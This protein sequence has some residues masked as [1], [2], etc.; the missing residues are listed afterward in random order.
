L[1]AR[2]QNLAG[3]LNGANYA[4]WDPEVDR[5]IPQK[6]SSN[7]L[8]FK[9]KNKQ[10]LLKRA[11]LNFEA[12]TPVIGMISRLESDKGFDLLEQAFDGLMAL[13]AQMIVLGVGEEKYHKM[14][15]RFAKKY[16][17]RLSV[18]LRFDNSLAHLIQ[19]GA[20]MLLMP[21]RCEPC[22][23]T[24]LHALRY[25]TIPIV[26]ATGG[27]ADTV[28][29]YEAKTEAGTGFVFKKEESEELIK[30][31]ERAIKLFQDRKRWSR[32]I[33]IAMKQDF[34]WEIAAERY[35]KVYT[36]LAARG[37]K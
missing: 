12:D 11:D 29:N 2:K 8:D 22:G 1:K 16:S 20:D 30:T 3:I 32:L 14:L 31:V 9:I 24:Q 10:E 27:L 5:F 35:T 6:Y 18:H 19:A 17:R 4:E 33:K 34:S 13:G 37:R 15:S 36:R 7:D 26:R 23:V 21:S 25:G 28:Q